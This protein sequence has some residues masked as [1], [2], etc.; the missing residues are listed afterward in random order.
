MKKALQTKILGVFAFSALLVLQQLSPTPW[1][2]VDLLYAMD[3][4]AYLPNLTPS[5]PI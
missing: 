2:Q 4:I 1:R 3:R 5:N